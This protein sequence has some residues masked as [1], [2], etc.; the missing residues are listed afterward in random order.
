MTN[1]I[2]DGKPA[3]IGPYGCFNL[4]PCKDT[5]YIQDGWTE[6]GRRNMVEMPFNSSR[7]CKYAEHGYAKDDVRC[8]G[9]EHMEEHN[10]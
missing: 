9:C 6:D 7:N 3:T 5:I 1:S 10:G 4:N 2:R 8:T